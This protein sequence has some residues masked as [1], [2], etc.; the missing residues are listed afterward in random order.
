[1]AATA[2]WGGAGEVNGSEAAGVWAETL[3][4][5][6]DELQGAL[7]AAEG[8]G[9]LDVR[10]GEAA[11]AIVR[12]VLRE[13]A[14]S[15]SRDAERELRL[16]EVLARR[17]RGRHVAV[18][19]KDLWGLSSLSTLLAVDD[20]AGGR[21]CA[22]FLAGTVG[23]VDASASQSRFADSLSSAVAL[24]AF[25]DNHLTHGARPLE[26]AIHDQS[27]AYVCYAFS[28]SLAGR[29]WL[30]S[31]ARALWADAV[32]SPLGCN[33]RYSEF[34]ALHQR[35]VREWRYRVGATAGKVRLIY[36][37]PLPGKASG[38]ITVS[39]RDGAFVNERRRQLELW[40]RYVSLHRLMSV[41]AP[42]RR[43]LLEPKGSAADAAQAGRGGRGGG[44]CIGRHKILAR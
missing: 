11:V 33:R 14:G 44:S 29:A 40:L 21:R 22:S 36:V 10:G 7:R 37:P 15:L 34:A 28:I 20:E 27:R 17:A 23:A 12:R 13:T 42:L 26:A 3:E 32:P 19:V 39:R 9:A 35:L 2:V 5:L 30:E 8:A 18:E 25:R 6:F 4:Q 24:A 1:M 38:R 41:S 43:V 16:R 31:E